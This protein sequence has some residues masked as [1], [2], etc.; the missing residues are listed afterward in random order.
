MPVQPGCRDRRCCRHAAIMSASGRMAST[1]P[2]GSRRT[3]ILWSCARQPVPS[4]RPTGPRARASWALPPFALS[5]GASRQWD[6]RPGPVR[7]D[8]SGSPGLYLLRRLAAARARRPVAARADAAL[9]RRRDGLASA[10]A[11]QSG[12]GGVRHDAAER[13]HGPAHDAVDGGAGVPARSA[14]RSR[15]RCARCR[16]GRAAGCSRVLHSRVAKVLTF[17]PLTFA[18][19]VISPWALYFTGWYDATLHSAFA[20]RADARAPGAR[21]L[22]VL[23]AAA[24]ASTRCPGGSPTRSGCCCRAHAA[25]PRVPRA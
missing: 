2:G 4:R 7:R 15:W 10:V 8:W 5:R 11:T 3:L 24:R 17:P 1:T 21:R 13:A 14:R 9:R 22:A 12:L 19:F 16:G 20:A 18:L 6:V 25:V 23:L